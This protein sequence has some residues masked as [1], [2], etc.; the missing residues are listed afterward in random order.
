MGLK[1][2][3]AGQGFSKEGTKES[4]YIIRV[5]VSPLRAHFEL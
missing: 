2:L 1:R 5:A 4:T 3:G